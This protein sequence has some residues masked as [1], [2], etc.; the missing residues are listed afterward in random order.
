MYLQY[1]KIY[2]LQCFYIYRNYTLESRYLE[3]IG[4]KISQ[5]KRNAL[6]LQPWIQLI[7]SN[8]QMFFS[9][10]ASSIRPQISFPI[11]YRIPKPEMP[12]GEPTLTQW[13]LIE[14]L[15]PEAYFYSG[16]FLVLQV[17][18]C[19]VILVNSLLQPHNPP[20]PKKTNQNKSK[21]HKVLNP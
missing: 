12:I 18:N 14:Y 2:L 20:S 8:S 21:T 7:P 4:Q 10:P 5:N 6:A 15:S 9:N 1:L 16:F 3:K 19:L 17:F 13:N 11:T